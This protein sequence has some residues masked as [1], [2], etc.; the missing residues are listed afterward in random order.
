MAGPSSTGSSSVVAGSLKK[1]ST[2]AA[3][4]S[5]SRT[6]TTPRVIGET[7]IWQSFGRELHDRQPEA[8][9][10]PDH[11]DEGVQVDGFADVA[12]GVQVVAL[13]DVL[14]GPRRR[15]HHDRDAPEVRVGLDLGQYLAAVLLGQ[16]Q[17]EQDQV[18][19]R[20]LSV[21]PLAPQERQRLD[22]VRD[23]AQVVVDPGVVERLAGQVD[24]G[25]TVL[26]EQDLDRRNAGGTSGPGLIAHGEAS[27]GSG[28]VNQKVDP[29][30]GVSSTQ[31]V[32]PWRST[33]RLQTA[34]PMPIPLSRTENS[35]AP[36]CRSESA[37][38]WRSAETWMRGGAS[39]RNL[40]ALATR[41]W[42]TWVNCVASPTT[43]GSGS[44]VTSAPLSSMARRRLASA[45][46]RTASNSTP[47]IATSR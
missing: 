25:G 26:H 34:R 2:S 6:R 13:D 8:V 41:F 35:H 4:S 15:E 44:W 1:K 28:I 30:P 17:V 45:R 32:P 42:N 36:C 27:P 5:T 47:A 19:M 20:G 9:D 40:M 12:V 37:D 16:V 24:V 38:G 11:F 21:L 18:R 7:V 29:P 3:L 14:L 31:S 23:H 46:S 33:I 39:P 10:R 22:T 43:V